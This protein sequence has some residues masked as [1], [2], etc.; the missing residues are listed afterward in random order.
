[1][2]EPITRMIYL[3]DEINNE[4]LSDVVSSILLFN[5]MDAEETKVNKHY[6][7]QPI[8]LYIN[9]FGGSVCDMW[10][11]IS[12]MD[13][14]KTPIYTYCTGYAMSAGFM[15]FIAGHR[16]F[17]GNHAQ[18]MYHQLSSGVI[19]TA[20]EIAECFEATEKEYEKMEAYVLSHTKISREKLRKIKERK[21]DWYIDPKEA[22]SLGIA[23][24]VMKYV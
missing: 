10:S 19:G 2:V 1:M 11:L 8:H 16:R 24:E 17:I 18:L 22:I 15:I 4:T 21:Q 14:S 13:A 7:R 20:Q 12:V 23:D 3:Q 5:K 6:V 9:T